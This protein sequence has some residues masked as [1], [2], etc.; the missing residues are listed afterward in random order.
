MLKVLLKIKQYIYEAKKNECFKTF[1]FPSSII[2]FSLAFK[3][4]DYNSGNSIETLKERFE[5]YKKYRKA[6]LEKKIKLVY[7][8]NN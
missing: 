2:K 3:C 6:S 7:K 4:L 1:I 5:L 8:S